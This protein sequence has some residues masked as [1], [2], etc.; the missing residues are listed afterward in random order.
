[1]TY[2]TCDICDGISGYILTGSRLIDVK[3]EYAMGIILMTETICVNLMSS[4][5]NNEIFSPRFSIFTL[6]LLTAE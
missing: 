1:M 2:V 6:P 5:C 4:S 3:V